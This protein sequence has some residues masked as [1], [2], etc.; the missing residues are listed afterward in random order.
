MQARIKAAGGQVLFHNGCRVMGALAM[1]RAVGD[2]ALRPYGVIA[3]PDVG[4][5]TRGDADEF[6]LLAS[7]GLWAAVSNQVRGSW[8][9]SCS[10]AVAQQCCRMRAAAGRLLVRLA[11]I[12]A[13]L[14]LTTAVP[15]LQDVVDIISKSLAELTALGL[16]RLQITAVLPKLLSK[17]AM[18]RGSGDNITVVL[19]DLRRDASTSGSSAA[20]CKSSDGSGSCDTSAAVA[21]IKRIIQDAAKQAWSSSSADAVKKGAP[22]AAARSSEAAA[23][24]DAPLVE[25]VS[26]FASAAAQLADDADAD[27]A[28]V[29]DVVAADSPSAL[30]GSFA[31][32]FLNARQQLGLSQVW[33]EWEAAIQCGACACAGSCGCGA[34]AAA[35]NPRKRRM[36]TTELGQAALGVSW[37]APAKLQQQHKHQQRDWFSAAPAAKRWAGV[38]QAPLSGCVALQTPA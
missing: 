19:H 3:D 34:A 15:G 35:A 1:S 9:A 6:L 27:A 4:H 10:A 21:C 20:G 17:V 25:A 30:G 12:R 2:H 18:A 38:A 16:S 8:P 13:P 33:H 22:A 32:P 14:L 7:D 11:N 28:V 36:V 26:V 5:Y 23:P 31:S 29:I 37:S 24:A